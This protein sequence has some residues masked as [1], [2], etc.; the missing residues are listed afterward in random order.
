MPLLMP[1]PITSDNG[2]RPDLLDDWLAAHSTRPERNPEFRILGP[3]EMRHG[4]SV[5]RPRGP[6]VRKL[7]ALLIVRANETVP[8]DHL[9]D[10]LWEGDPPA[11]AVN[12]VR[13]HVY[14]L[15]Q[16]LGQWLGHEA[17]Q[18]LLTTE[19]TGYALNAEEHQTDLAV[20]RRTCARGRQELRAGHLEAAYESFGDALGMWRGPALADVRQGHVLAAH[21][22][23]IEE[24]QLHAQEKWIE[25]AM[26]LGYYREVLPQ[27]RNLVASHPY[28][29]WLHARLIDALHQSGRR[30]DALRAFQDVRT[31]LA[32]ELGLEPSED[33]RRM[34]RCVLVGSRAS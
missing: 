16:E 28:N 2:S 21:A 34:Q 33:L 8:V 11:T 14:H 25:V 19:A 6:K 27:L 5:Y 29:E 15:R 30:G 12:T 10:E 9:I 22:R 13:T 18:D 32:H 24:L 31:V 26:R 4:A 3:L 23:E 7:L 17:V 1:Q 20:F